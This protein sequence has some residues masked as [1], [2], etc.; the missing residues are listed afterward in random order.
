MFAI[1]EIGSRQYKVAKDEII[2]IP[3][4]ENKKEISLTNVL[5]IADG[6]QVQLGNPYIKKAKIVCEVLGDVK[7]PKTIAFKYKRRKSSQ[8]TVGHRDALTKL[9]V[10][11]I[12]K[13]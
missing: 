13:E 2:C 3:R 7:G 5:L 4:I 10:K 1:A 6:S 12:V 8:R 9:K 11:D